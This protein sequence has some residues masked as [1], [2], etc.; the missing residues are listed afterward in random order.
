MAD[1]GMSETEARALTEG[2]L[3]GGKIRYRQFAAGH[4]S[5]FE[6]VLLAASVPVKPGETVLEAGTGAGA[7]LLCLNRRVAGV[8]GTGVEI[9]PELAE[10]ANENFK[11]NG[12][13]SYSC[14]CADIGQAGF[15][16]VFDHAMANPPWHGAAS[17]K[18]PDAKRALA[19]HAGPGL[20]KQW[21]G[22]LSACLKPRGG[23]TLILPAAL[24]GEASAC[25][26][27]HRY[28]AIQLFPL[29]P[30]AGQPAKLVIIA[31]RR[32]AGGPDKVLPGLVLHDQNGITEAAQSILRDGKPTALAT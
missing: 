8:A 22:G 13:S 32:G 24:Y 7:A 9:V 11:I 3:L 29:W 4:R 18:S 27:Q 5:G 20:L 1:A 25:L 15:G 17:T 21:I 28:G 26:R 31:A 16:A 12:L 6:P 14:V 30:R 2:S 23:L 19:H 10:L